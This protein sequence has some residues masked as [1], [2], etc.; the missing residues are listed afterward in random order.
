MRDFLFPETGPFARS[1]YKKHMEFIKA[2]K[3]YHEVAFIAANRSAKSWTG[4]Q[5][6][7]NAAE[8]IYPDWWEGRKF[9]RPVKIWC[10]G[11][12]GNMVRDTIQ[13]ILCGPI[14]Q[15]GTGMLRAHPKLRT[16]VKQGISG[17]ILDVFV[18]HV[19]GG[20][21]QITFK[22]YDQD[23]ESFMGAKIDLLWCDEECVHDKIY[24]EAVMRTAGTAGEPG[25]L[26]IVTYTP[27]NSLTDMVLKFLPHAQ[28][29]LDGI[30]RDDNGEPLSRYTVNCGW[31]DIPHLSEEEK[32]RL[33]DAMD[34][35]ERDARTKGL[36][37][38]G[39]G[40]V[41]P[42]DWANVIIDPFQIPD[43]WDKA[44]GLDP[45]MNTAAVFGAR[46]PQ[47]GITYIYSEYVGFKQVPAVH[48]SA[49][50]ARGDWLIGAFDYS[51]NAVG[52]GGEA[53]LRT[54]YHDE[55]LTLVNSDKCFYTS[56]SKM[57]LGF[58]AGTL[59]IFNS[60]IQTL[61]SLRTYRYD[62]NP[63][64]LGKPKPHQFDH[65][66]DGFRYLMNTPNIFAPNPYVYDRFAG[67]DQ[68]YNDSTRNPVT[69]Y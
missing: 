1:K 10:V 54:V 12:S 2:T 16:T 25:G 56:T 7:A 39:T 68:I 51:G 36:P 3:D 43:W 45:G 17:A 67:M 9:D 21:S 6:I 37:S 29:P 30:V 27:L 5:I 59:K 15:L 24:N 48:A 44:Y 19:S 64:N 55:G 32:K 62:D 66:V 47:T 69:G 60:C 28:F 57:L 11:K 50:K 61:N 18:P 20:E 33:Y 46:D 38:L 34:P 52:T 49:I 41:F 23:V 22:T 35:R 8:G 31:D 13:E 53:S 65:P 42:I 14:G 4:A 40:M 58:E 26:T 63:N